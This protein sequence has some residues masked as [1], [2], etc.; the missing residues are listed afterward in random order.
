MW[1]PGKGLWGIIGEEGR[2][3]SCHFWRSSSSFELRSRC[4]DSFSRAKE[5]R[6]SV[7]VASRV[8]IWERSFETR[9]D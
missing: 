6:R 2:E 1:E 5:A 4:Q 3:F 9:L 8:V 7:S